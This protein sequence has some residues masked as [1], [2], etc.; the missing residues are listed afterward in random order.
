M[1]WGWLKMALIS[2]LTAIADAIRSKTE[3]TE[4]L[5]LDEMPSAIEGIQSGGSSAWDY[6]TGIYFKQAVFPNNYDLVLN[7]HAFLSTG[8]QVIFMQST[9]L[10]SIKLITKNKENGEIANSNAF[11]QDSKT[12]ILELIDLSEF[13]TKI[14]NPMNAFLGC[15]KLVTILGELDFSGSTSLSGVFSTDDITKGA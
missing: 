7:V 8:S 12:T 5:T 6:S 13:I 10:R 15:S 2:K 3:T 11:Y 1:L 14:K 9:G 4:K